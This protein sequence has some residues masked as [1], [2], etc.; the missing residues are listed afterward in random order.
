MHAIFNKNQYISISSICTRVH[1][2]VYRL[3]DNWT[4]SVTALHMS[5]HNISSYAALQCML[6]LRQLVF[7]FQYV[8]SAPMEEYAAMINVRRKN[9]SHIDSAEDLYGENRWASL[10]ARPLCGRCNLIT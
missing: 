3:S 8:Y 2:P 9:K 5:V 6:M 1:L 10:H 7:I 4:H